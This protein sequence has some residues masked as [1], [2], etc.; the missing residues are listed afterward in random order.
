MPNKMNM[1]YSK[2]SINRASKFVIENCESKHFFLKGIVGAGKTTLVKEICKDL[3]VLDIV[4]SPTFSIINEYKTRE[5]KVIFH[6]DLFRLENKNEIND[7]GI[8]EYL[9]NKN[10][11][12]IEWPELLL[13]SHHINH[14][15]IEIDYIGDEERKITISNIIT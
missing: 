12:I 10:F 3:H 5:N 7:L 9:D 11:V 4:N 1:I 6:M 15:L 2:E 13:K 8:T 14:S